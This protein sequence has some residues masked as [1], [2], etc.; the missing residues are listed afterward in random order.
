MIVG[1]VV[2]FVD[3]DVAFPAKNGSILLAKQKRASFLQREKKL[4]LER[5]RECVEEFN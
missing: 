5:E 2:G 4:N 1:V 3:W